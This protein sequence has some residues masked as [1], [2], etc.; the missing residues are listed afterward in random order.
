[1]DTKCACACACADAVLAVDVEA[2]NAKLDLGEYA[3]ARVEV[4]AIAQRLYH[5]RMCVGSGAG[6][7]SWRDGTDE[8]GASAGRW[9]RGTVW[10]RRR[11]LKRCAVLVGGWRGVV[12]ARQPRD[13]PYGRLAHCRTIPRDSALQRRRM[14]G[15]RICRADDRQGRHL[16]QLCNAGGTTL[17]QKNGGAR[18]Y[19]GRRIE[20]CTNCRECDLPAKRRPPSHL[21]GRCHLQL[22]ARPGLVDCSSY[23]REASLSEFLLPETA[24]GQLSIGIYPRHGEQ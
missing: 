13:Q 24:A 1:M 22:D 15:L 14:A 21:H 12:R 9:E 17:P 2:V 6:V 7:V 23:G 10:M 19:P 11:G 20:F 18:I 5:L 8:G 3:T 16:G 4:A